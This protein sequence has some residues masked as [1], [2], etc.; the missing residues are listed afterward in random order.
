MTKTRRLLGV[1]AILALL[2]APVAANPLAW[3]QTEDATGN[4]AMKGGANVANWSGGPISPSSVY[5]GAASGNLSTTVYQAATNTNGAGYDEGI[6]VAGSLAADSTAILRF[7]MPQVIPGGTLKLRIL[8]LAN[9]SSHAVHLVVSDKN[10]SA[11]GGNPA[12]ATLNAETETTM[13]FTAADSYLE[14]D[15][16][17]TSTPA[18]GDMLVVTIKFCQNSGG[19]CATPGWGLTTTSVFM[20]TIVWK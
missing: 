10:V 12:T 9:D 3:S 20:P 15:V 6:G 8:A 5:L 1:V 16:P 7:T 14:A 2:A 11:S 18:A 17:L 13:T 4:L 19:S